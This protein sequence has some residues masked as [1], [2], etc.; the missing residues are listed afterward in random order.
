MRKKGALF[1]AHPF[2]QV[3]DDAK[4]YTAALAAA[5]VDRRYPDR[6]H[7]PFLYK[8]SGAKGIIKTVIR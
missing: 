5:L 1:L 8:S 4:N 3:L 7:N 6:A 2:L